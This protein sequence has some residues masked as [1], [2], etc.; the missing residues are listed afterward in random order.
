M[1]D[2]LYTPEFIETVKHA[3]AQC[4][5]VKDDPSLPAIERFKPISM[6]Y[7][8]AMHKAAIDKKHK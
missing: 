1:N 8:L 2:N 7:I 6:L 4:E 5:K 3:I